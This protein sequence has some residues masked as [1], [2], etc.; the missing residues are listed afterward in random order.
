[1]VV[2][3]AVVCNKC[4][5]CMVIMV[6]RNNE[7]VLLHGVVKWLRSV[8]VGWCLG[9]CLCIGE[10]KRGDSLGEAGAGGK[11]ALWFRCVSISV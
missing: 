6:W 1:M 3:I 10:G 8:T 7:P 11:V 9:V 2:T 4:G 5:C